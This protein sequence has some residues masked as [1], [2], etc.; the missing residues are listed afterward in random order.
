[1]IVVGTRP[2]LIKVAPV[3]WELAKNNIPFNFI[4]SNQHYS[5]ELDANIIKN[6]DIPKPDFH[7]HVG[8]GSHAM[9][10]G[11]VMESIEGVYKK[12]HPSVVVV[13]G[14][15]NTTLGAALAAAKL[16]IPVAHIEAGLRS[17]DYAMPEE[18]NRM[19]VDRISTVLFAPTIVSF[20]NLRK[21]GIDKKKIVVTG[22]TIVDVLYWYKK[23]SNGGT[24]K[25]PVKKPYILVTA[26]RQEN[27]DNKNQ[28]KKILELLH[29]LSSQTHM[30]ILWPIH[31]RTRSNLMKFDLSIH[32]SEIKVISPV[33]YFQMISFL[34]NASLVVTDS[35]GI[36]EEAYVLK[37]P[38]L[39]IRTTTERPETLSAN[40]IT[41]LDAK[42]VIRGWKRYQNGY[43]VWNSLLGKG[44]AA[45]KIVERLK[46]FI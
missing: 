40:I 14:D 8:S 34:T 2:E 30:N 5:Q 32:D 26:H 23:V 1:M 9:Q 13:H 17:F 4:H 3:M 38:L 7:L 45:I 6:L 43:G 42:K 33:D 44:D 27:V 25:P 12:I 41:G 21:E 37:K 16:N 20:G 46:T 24:F 10:T 31:P 15:T 22:N 36:Q 39:T 29:M 18:I 35:G 19:L 28:L 11:K